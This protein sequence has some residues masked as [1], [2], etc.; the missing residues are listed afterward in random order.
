MAKKRSSELD[1]EIRESLARISKK[2][3]LKTP[4]QLDAEIDTILAAGSRAE[5]YEIA[6]ALGF[7]YP[8]RPP[9]KKMT[10][11]GTNIFALTE[12][13]LN[14]GGHSTFS[15]RLAQVDY[16][17]IKRCLAAGLVEVSSPS[18]LTLTHVGREAV[19]RDLRENY[20]HK[21]SGLARD[22]SRYDARDRARI[23]QL[24]E[25]ITNLESGA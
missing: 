25:A 2:P 22:P 14:A 19:L 3:G 16:P 9:P 7:R 23:E 20:G 15:N 18:T 5:R 1:Q 6:Q 17:H 4:A 11:T 12:Q 13:V 24:R 8:K 10:I 21:S